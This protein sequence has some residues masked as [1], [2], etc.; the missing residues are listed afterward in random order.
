M[1]KKT[2]WFLGLWLFGVTAV[3]ALAFVIRLALHP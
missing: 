1:L 2:A 3:G